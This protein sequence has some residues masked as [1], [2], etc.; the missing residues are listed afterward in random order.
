MAAGL[1]LRLIPAGDLT[2]WPAI[3][4]LTDLV[5]GA[6]QRF[7][8]PQDLVQQDRLAESLSRRERLSE[9]ATQQELA[10]CRIRWNRWPRPD[11]FFTSRR[12]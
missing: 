3:R 2:R 7:R 8:Q 1:T 5:C 11:P 10:V 6:L 9:L 12:R 4:R